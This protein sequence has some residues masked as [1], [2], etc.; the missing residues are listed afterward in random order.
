MISFGLSRAGRA[1]GHT[2]SQAIGASL[3]VSLAGLVDLT[4]AALLA[5]TWTQLPVSTTQPQQSQA[6]VLRTAAC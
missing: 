5:V 1:P 3:A 4:A 6:A 2:A